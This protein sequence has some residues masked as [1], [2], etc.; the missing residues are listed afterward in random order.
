MRLTS[1]LVAGL[2][3]LSVAA[4]DLASAQQSKKPFTVADDI[5]M[6]LFGDSRQTVRFSP[7][8]NYVAVYSQR[9]RL[10]LN[11]VEDSLRFYRSQDVEDFLKHFDESQPPSPVWVMNRSSKEGPIIND[12]RWLADSSGVAF[13]QSAAGGNRCLVFADLRK[14]TVEPLTLPMEMVKDFDIRDRRHYVYTADDSAG[15]EKWQAQREAEHQ[16]PA[17]VGTGRSLWQLL[18]PDESK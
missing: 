16:A 1:F 5:E 15:R 14:K 11:R 9:A 18:F 12:W 2:I 10:D 13:L 8:G 4:C 3:G 7:D 6:A 17:V